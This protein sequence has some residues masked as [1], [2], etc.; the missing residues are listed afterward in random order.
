MLTLPQLTAAL[1][2]LPDGKSA[3]L[4]STGDLDVIAASNPVSPPGKITTVLL[5]YIE[6]QKIF[7]W[8]GLDLTK[9]NPGWFTELRLSVQSR[10]PIEQAYFDNN[11]LP[12]DQVVGIISDWTA[13]EHPQ[14]LTFQGPRNANLNPGTLAIWTFINSHPSAEFDFNC[15]RGNAHIYKTN[16]TCIYTDCALSNELEVYAIAALLDNVSNIHGWTIDISG[17]C[18]PPNSAVRDKIE[19]ARS[20]GCRVIHNT[21]AWPFPTAETEPEEE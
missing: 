11:L 14:R 7:N 13:A 9:F 21:S 19:T 10:A 12:F 15:G 1:A 20:R 2:D 16:K 18:L 17:T 6:N 5:R 4:D 3:L 8:S